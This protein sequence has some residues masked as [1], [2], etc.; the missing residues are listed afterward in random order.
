VNN[1]IENITNSDFIQLVSILISSLIAIISIVISV[2]TLRQTNKITQ[3][4]NRP[5]V[6]VYLETISVTGTPMLYLVLKN[7]GKS[8]AVIDSITYSPK[9]KSKF[10][11]EPFISMLNYF[12]APNQSVTTAYSNEDNSAVT[13]T[14][15][16]HDN[17]KSY[18][19]SFEI[20]QNAI[21]E[22]LLIKTHN[23]GM[24]LEKSISYAFQE[25]IRT[26]L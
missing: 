4:A 17:R 20:N 26:R 25:L 12:I 7:F 14:I 3:E 18:I 10:E 5:Y 2:L 11:R 15:K 23:T 24:D 6:V 21:R 22:C 1:L 13:F 19:D 8:G 16:Y 9:Y